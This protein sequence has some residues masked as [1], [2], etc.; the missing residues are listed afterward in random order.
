[1]VGAARKGCLPNQIGGNVEKRV[2]F[3]FL[4]R[5]T[6]VGLATSYNMA[7]TWVFSL[8]KRAVGAI[9]NL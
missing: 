8:E 5:P 6:K 3:L 4:T 2:T 1:M 9:H 7:P